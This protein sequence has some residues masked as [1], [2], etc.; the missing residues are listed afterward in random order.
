MSKP[1]QID[2]T[3]SNATSPEDNILRGLFTF[4]LNRGSFDERMRRA[5]LKPASAR[6]DHVGMAFFKLHQEAVKEEFLKWAA[7]D[8][9][10]NYLLSSKSVLE[11]FRDRMKNLGYLSP[12]DTILGARYKEVTG[13]D[14]ARLPRDLKKSFYVKAHNRLMKFVTEWGSSTKFNRHCHQADGSN[15]KELDVKEWLEFAL[16]KKNKN[17]WLQSD[18]LREIRGLYWKTMK[19]E[20]VADVVRELMD[21]AAVAGVMLS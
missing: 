6:T 11:A 12:F 1:V 20:P 9:L 8:N 3:M 16:A 17:A 2:F 4:F 15:G 19:H 21:Q 10:A 13:F 14:R 5:K 18:P 7:K